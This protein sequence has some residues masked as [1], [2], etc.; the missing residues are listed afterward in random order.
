MTIKSKL[1]MIATI[2]ALGIASP[3]FAQSFD[4]EAGTGN[5]LPSAYV[6]ETLVEL[7]AVAF[8]ASTEGLRAFAMVPRAG[9]TTVNSNDPSLTGGGSVGYNE[10]LEQY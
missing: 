3:A 9:H 1:A 7:P 8:P 6:G 5:V 2:A 4:P 10:L